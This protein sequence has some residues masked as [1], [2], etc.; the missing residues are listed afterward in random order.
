M[1]SHTHFESLIIQFT[2]GINNELPHKVLIENGA[3][4]NWTF[5][6]Q[7]PRE[8]ERKKKIEEGE[9]ERIQLKSTV[10]LC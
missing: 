10:C 9:R 5:L 1:F 7:R 4:F 8:K 3:P 2:N 6:Q